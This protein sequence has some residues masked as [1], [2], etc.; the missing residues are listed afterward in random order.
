VLIPIAIAPVVD[1]AD[2]RAR[3]AWIRRWGESVE[4]LFI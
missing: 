4:R 2:A 3:D 1:F